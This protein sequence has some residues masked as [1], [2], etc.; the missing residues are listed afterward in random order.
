MELID[1]T[2]TRAAD[3]DRDISDV[4][5]L[6]VKA[7]AL[8]IEKL[9]ARIQQVAE[10]ETRKQAATELA[11]RV[12]VSTPETRDAGG[13]KVTSEEPTYHARGRNSFLVDAMASE[14]SS[15]FDAAERIQRYN[16]ELKL[17]KRDVGTG[18]F[19]GLVVPQ[20]LIDLYANLA[21]AGRP[22]ANI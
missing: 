6:N 8:E 15:D 9:D 17:E 19:A 12:E 18:N 5:D 22:V 11:K 3:E 1:A 4:E 13:W 16:R 2:L 20:Y 21:R 7:L 10:I 14:F